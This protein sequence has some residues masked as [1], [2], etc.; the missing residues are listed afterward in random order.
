MSDDFGPEDRLGV[1][2]VQAS[3]GF[4]DAFQYL[5]ALTLQDAKD[6]FPNSLYQLNSIATAAHERW[7]AYAN[8]ELALPDGRKMHRWSG[9]YARSIKIEVDSREGDGALL[10][11]VISSDDPKA[12]WI[13]TGTAAWDM[14]KMLQTSHKVRQTAE[15]KR[16]LVIPFRWGTP[17][18]LVV[19]AYVGR[20]M[21]EQVHQF[22]LN[23]VPESFITGT[24]QQPSLIDPDVMVDRYSYQWGGN[25]TPRDLNELG[26]DPNTAPG[27][28]MVGMYR[29]N[30]P[31]VGGHAQHVTFRTISENSPEGTWM[32]PG[33]EGKYPALAVAEWV[34]RE[35]HAAMNAAL[36]AD[37]E[38]IR[39]LAERQTGASRE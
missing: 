23:R 10:T 2:D 35:M 4:P 30:D 9:E 19:G 3:I 38:R 24:Y 13:E 7:L 6:L 28:H 31:E 14:R 1:Y 34:E 20:E 12:F 29:M 32:H 16:Y 33:T 36:D 26:I 22:M 18:T 8:G 21:T 25:L 11:Y 15:G 37:L 5:L 17:K 27:R 39:D